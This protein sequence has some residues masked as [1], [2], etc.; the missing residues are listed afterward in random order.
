MVSPTWIFMVDCT[1]QV[2]IRRNTGTDYMMHVLQ[3][4]WHQTQKRKKIMKNIKTTV[5]DNVDMHVIEAPNYLTKPIP[6][7]EQ[8]MSC[9]ENGYLEGNVLFDMSE[10]VTEDEET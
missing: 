1:G 6:L 8:W 10:L 9:D 7:M 2:S 3:I 5:S 4:I